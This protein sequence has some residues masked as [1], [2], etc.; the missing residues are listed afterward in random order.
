MPPFALAT[1]YHVEN[2]RTV[3]HA[4]P[5]MIGALLVLALAYRY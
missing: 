1:L 2:G 4:M 5:V 3:Y